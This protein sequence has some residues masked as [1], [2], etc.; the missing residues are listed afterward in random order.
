MKVVAIGSLEH[1][2]FIPCI[3]FEIRYDEY[4]YSGSLN[5]SQEDRMSRPLNYRVEITSAGHRSYE[6][7]SREKA[8]EFISDVAGKFQIDDMINLDKYF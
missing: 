7:Q 3:G 6:F 8:L 2:F 1:G 5:E 4:R